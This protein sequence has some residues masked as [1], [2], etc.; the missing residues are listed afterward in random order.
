MVF[1]K[2][3]IK[4]VNKHEIALPHLCYQTTNWSPMRYYTSKGI[5]NNNTTSNSNISNTLVKVLSLSITV[6]IMLKLLVLYPVEM[7]GMCTEI[8]VQEY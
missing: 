8:H 6:E 7:Y 3:D 2:D 1:S 4:M 5:S